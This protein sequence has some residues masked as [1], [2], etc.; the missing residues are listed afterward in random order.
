MPLS[1]IMES[2]DGLSP[3]IAELY[4]EKDGKFELTGISGVQTQGNV[5]RLTTALQKERDEHKATRD[6][7]GV[8][9]DMSHE[10]TMAQLDRIP[11]LEAA[12][13]GNLDEAQIEE[14]VQR[15]TEGTIKSQ[16]APVERKLAN[17][18]KENGELK[19]ENGVLKQ[20]IVTRDIED[21]TRAPLLDSKIHATALDD[22]MMVAR[23]V[24]E[25]TEDGAIVT[26]ENPFG[27]TVGL[28]PKSFIAEAQEKRRHW[29]PES[30]GG[31]AGGGNGG[32]NLS[33]EN[34]WKGESW[35][36]TA[37]AKIVRDSPERAERLAKQAGVKVNATKPAS[38]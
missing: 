15:R 33:G 2:M 5:D 24:F 4:T 20:Q 12:S 6:K 26:K 29:W 38:K 7:L 31:G 34:P 1:A 3:E 22:A 8:W 18:E 32:G 19:S 10:E 17:Y 11:E 37:Q 25:K 16:L 21:A 23:N 30:A 28:D 35:N 9:G 27:F 36:K 14:M 13:K